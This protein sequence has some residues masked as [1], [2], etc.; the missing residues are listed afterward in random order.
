MVG[1]RRSNC[2]KRSAP[3]RERL[4]RLYAL[5]DARSGEC[6]RVVRG[7]EYQ[8]APCIQGNQSAYQP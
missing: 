6:T 7:M 1:V 2:P 4:A 5:A 8:P 3:M